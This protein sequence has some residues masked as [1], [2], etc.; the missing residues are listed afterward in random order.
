ML[1]ALRSGLTLELLA[2][3]A[4][5]LP[6]TQSILLADLHVGK[7]QSFRR[8][9]LPVPAGTTE[10]ALSRIDA[11]LRMRPARE[12]IILGDF[13]HDRY[14]Q[15]SDSLRQF[16]AWRSGHCALP[17]H[18]VRGNHDARAGDPPPECGL[19]VHGAAIIR[20]GLLLC[21]EATPRSD[22]FVVAGHVHPVV[23]LTGAIDR[24]RLPCF[25]L[26][27]HA[28]ILPAFGEFTGGW[29]VEPAPG[30]RLFAS[31]GERV[32]EIPAVRVARRRRWGS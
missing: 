31:D 32:V 18:L 26:R 25:W 4:M 20:A 29:P 9:G 23:R 28:L 22:D 6:A 7:A 2:D 27:E 11:L 15:R 8:Q 21:H 10:A 3:R 30:D 19:T 12:L 16:A 24:L 14:A 1:I 13:L 5:W 17:I